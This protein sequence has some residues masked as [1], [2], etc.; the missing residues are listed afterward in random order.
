[1]KGII[2]RFLK[3]LLVI[4]VVLLIISAILGLAL[5]VVFAR[6]TAVSEYGDLPPILGMLGWGTVLFFIVLSGISIGYIFILK[7][8][9]ELLEAGEGH[10][11]NILLLIG[12]LFSILMIAPFCI[13]SLF[14]FD[15]IVAKTLLVQLIYWF[16]M[17]FIFLALLHSLY[18]VVFLAIS[19]KIKRR[20]REENK[21][22]REHINEIHRN[23]MPYGSA[24]SATQNPYAINKNSNRRR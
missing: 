9:F 19:S 1:M 3:A 18:S 8:N 15:D 16:F 6:D 12:R 24:Y 14:Y 4:M 10:S 22:M 11:F 23:T 17:N 20:I 5:C 7:H 2:M 21:I 13:S